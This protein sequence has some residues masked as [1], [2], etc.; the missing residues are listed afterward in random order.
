[1]S[2][3]DFQ[4]LQT[5]LADDLQVRLTTTYERGT[6]SDSDSRMSTDTVDEVR[7]VGSVRSLHTTHYSLL[8]AANATNAGSLT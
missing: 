1:M 7:S 4:I 2:K 5:Q 3:A 8:Y 6:R